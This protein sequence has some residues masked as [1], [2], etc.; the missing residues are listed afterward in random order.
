MNFQ[1]PP[2]L[3]ANVVAGRP[4]IKKSLNRDLQILD[5]LRSLFGNLIKQYCH[6]FA[7]PEFKFLV[8]V[9]LGLLVQNTV[10]KESLTQF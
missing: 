9:S 8:A 5:L 4:W 10:L 3:V 2:I 1:L 6:C 7:I